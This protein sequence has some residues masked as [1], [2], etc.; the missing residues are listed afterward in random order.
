MEECLTYEESKSNADVH[1]MR[2]QIYLA[3]LQQ[4]NTLKQTGKVYS[5]DKKAAL[6][7]LEGFDKAVKLGTSKS[8][9]RT[10]IEQLVLLQ[11]YLNML[12]ADASEAK[13]YSTSMEAFKGLISS[14][15]ILNANKTKSA[16]DEPKTFTDVAG[17]VL[18]LGQE[19]KRLPELEDFSLELIANKTKGHDIPN[20]YLTLYNLNK[21][22][23]EARAIGFIEEGRRRHKDDQSLL[24]AEINHY[25]GKGQLSSLTD[26]LQQAIDKDPKN[27][28]LYLTMGTVLEQL[29]NQDNTGLT[30]DQ[31]V[32]YRTRALA[33]YKK[34]VEVDEKFFDGYYSIGVYY[35]NQA[36]A[37]SEEL[38]ALGADFSKEGQKKYEAKEKQMLEAFAVALPYFQ[39][40]EALNANDQAVLQALREIYTRTGKITEAN[41][42]KSRLDK[43]Q[44]G[45]KNEKSYHN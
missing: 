6:K 44:A 21:D 25:L 13:D 42:F 45:G 19:S 36:A 2:G 23:D 26:K 24:Y 14:H 22:K 34:S 30:A 33:N 12:G 43:L 10:S 29:S 18:L 35:Y 11:P 38:N 32:E 9:T 40:A 39:K 7:A 41:E 28:S 31:K 3:Q 15:A 8:A 5:P 37:L 20:A 16:L 27:A 4:E 1:V 17:Y